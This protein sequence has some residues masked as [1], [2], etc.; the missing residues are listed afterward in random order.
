ME[1]MATAM[2]PMIAFTGED[3]DHT[4]FDHGRPRSNRLFQ[5]RPYQTKKSQRKAEGTTERIWLTQLEIKLKLL[6]KCTILMP[7]YK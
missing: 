5:V 6:Y 3:Y 2:Q 7:I 1:Q 4:S